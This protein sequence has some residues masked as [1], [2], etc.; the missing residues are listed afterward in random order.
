VAYGT[1]VDKVR[2]MMV[3]TVRQVEGVVLDKPVMARYD[4]MGD[5]SMIFSMEYWV[6]SIADERAVPDPVNRALQ[7]ALDIA[8]IKMPYPMQNVHFQVEPETVSRL[9]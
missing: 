5:S 2:Q 8:G 9:S 6:E 4:R 7:Q 3:D 1:D